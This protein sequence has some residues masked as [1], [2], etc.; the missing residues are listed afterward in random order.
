MLN[1]QPEEVRNRL[2]RRADWRF[3]LPNP[4]PTNSICFANG[5]LAKAVG[6]ISTTMVETT[7]DYP[8]NKFDL[9]VAVDPDIA[10]L[11]RAWSALAPGGSLYTE[12]HSYW[13]PRVRQIRKRLEAVG[14]EEINYFSA[15]PNPDLTT[16]EVWL[17]YKTPLDLNG[18]LANLKCTGKLGSPVVRALRQLARFLNSL[19]SLGSPVSVAARKKA[20]S[21]ERARKTRN[22]S[23]VIPSDFRNEL[24]KT[25]RAGWSEWGFGE[26]P[27]RLEWMLL[28]GGQRSISKVVA[29]VSGDE[30]KKGQLAIKI[31]R[32]FESISSLTREAE[33]LR[34]L[35]TK[36]NLPGVPKLLFCQQHTG[37]LTVGETFLAGIPLFKL[38]CHDNCRD[39]ALTATRWLAD[40]AGRAEPIPP[41]TWRKRLI[42]PVIADFDASFGPILDTGLF[43]TSTDC[44]ATLGPLPIVCEQ[45]DFAPWNL[46]ITD[47]GNLA[48]LDWESSELQ[49]LP[50]L[51]LIYFL[52]Y[53]TFSLNKAKSLDDF[54]HS[55]S[56]MLNP[57]TLSG[58]IADECL[59]LYLIQTGLSP[60]LLRPLRLLTWLIH[61]RSEYQ[62]LVADS[63]G[64]P[65]RDTL[66][67]SLFLNLWETELRQN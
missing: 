6:L 7:A 2:L 12:W 4:N 13:V 5:S 9:A 59:R 41:A 15:R 37:V 54:Q 66:R 29:V 11:K 25:I 47:A 64:K 32:V 60:A 45:R 17:P 10:T 19:I 1:D 43:R 52:T 50:A 39:L 56:A 63:A 20:F 48:V 65:V 22:P 33:N 49:G 27:K 67:R 34:T 30:D 46:L 18:F 16:P 21:A 42:D 36:G 61:S 14:F 26:T 3:L 58:S 62:R 38:L 31:P 57:S 23:A 24:M 8:S 44:L 55:Y 35:S 40:F 53:M 28:T 51:D